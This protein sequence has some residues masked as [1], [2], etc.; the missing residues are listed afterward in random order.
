MPRSAWSAARG[1][2]FVD[3]EVLDPGDGEVELFGEVPVGPSRAGVAPGDELGAMVGVA[4]GLPLA[5]SIMRACAPIVSIGKPGHGDV[6]PMQTDLADT[7]NSLALRKV[8]TSK[9]MARHP[10]QS[11]PDHTSPPWQ[12]T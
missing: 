12:V 9:S 7:C 1:R 11:P 6:A 4:P 10:G 3:A 8:C 2:S 5:V